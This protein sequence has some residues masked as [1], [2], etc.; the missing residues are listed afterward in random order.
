MQDVILSSD[1][2]A[3]VQNCRNTD[4][5]F[6]NHRISKDISNLGRKL[7][8]FPLKGRQES[9]VPKWWKGAFIENKVN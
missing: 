8:S 2:I 1:I 3:K 9:Y 4:R 7:S 5:F 6:E